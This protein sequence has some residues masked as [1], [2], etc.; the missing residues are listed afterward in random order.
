M[1]SSGAEK[2][3]QRVLMGTEFPEQLAAA[4]GKERLALLEAAGLNAIQPVRSINE[5]QSI[6]SGQS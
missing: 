4:K 1:A 2:F 3:L 6:S 5:T